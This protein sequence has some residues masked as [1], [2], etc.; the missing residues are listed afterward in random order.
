MRNIWVLALFWKVVLSLHSRWMAGRARRWHPKAGILAI[1]AVFI[2]TASSLTI[3]SFLRALRFRETNILFFQMLPRHARLND[4]SLAP[5][6]VSDSEF[7]RM[8]DAKTV[9][10]ASLVVFSGVVVLQLAVKLITHRTPNFAFCRSF[11]IPL[12]AGALY[13]KSMHGIFWYIRC[14]QPYEQEQPLVGRR[15]SWERVKTSFASLIAPSKPPRRPPRGCSG[16]DSPLTML[17]WRNIQGCVRHE[18]MF[19]VESRSTE[20]WSV[21]RLVNI[22]LLSDPWQL[23]QLYGVGR[24]VYL[25]CLIA[26]QWTLGKHEVDSMRLVLLPRR[27]RTP[28]Q[29]GDIGHLDLVAVIDSSV[30]PWT[31]LVDC[32]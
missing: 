21:I 9:I 16:C 25:Y 6:Y 11:Y 7:G 10:L 18:R 12:S 5:A 15:S 24:P 1:R 19:S 27:L 28:C 22:A 23:V 8:I 2:S 32:G 17:H 20:L 13:P 26:P 30:V 3:F 31:A 4:E 14:K 29:H